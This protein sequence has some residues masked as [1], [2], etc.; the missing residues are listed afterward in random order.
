MGDSERGKTLQEEED[1]TAEFA[2]QCAQSWPDLLCRGKS[3]N[4]AETLAEFGEICEADAHT[5]KVDVLRT[6][7]AHPAFS[8]PEM[9]GRLQELLTDFCLAEGV[10][11]MQGLHEVAAVFAYIEAAG[12]GF[13]SSKPQCPTTLD[14]FKIFTRSFMPCFYDGEGFV[15]LHITLLFF[16]QLLLYHLPHLHNQLEEAGVAPVVYATP[17][18]I[19]LFAYK[20][21]LQVLLRLWHRYIR[22]GD[23]TFVP[24]LAVA[25][26]ELEKQAF[27]DAEEDDLNYAVDRTTITSLEKLQDVWN[28]A[29]I[30]HAKTPKSFSFRMSRVIMQVR[31]QLRKKGSGHPWADSVLARAEQE[32]RLVVLAREVVAQFVR[33]SDPAST[34][35]DSVQAVPSGQLPS[36]RLLLL[37]VRPRNAYDAEHLPNALHFHP[38]SLQRLAQVSAGMSRP[39]A[40]RLAA[41]LS[42]AISE[43]GG[44]VGA[45]KEA[46]EVKAGESTPEGGE[47][48]ALGAE[49]F[50][51]L[52]AAASEAWG[53]GWIS[54]SESAHL[55]VLGG[56]ADWDAAQI[57]KTDGGGVVAAL[58]EALTGQI[59]LPRVSV[60]LGGAAALQREA[61]KRGLKLESSASSA[62]KTDS[63][64][65]GN[66]RGLLSGA[67]ASLR[68]RAQQAQ[69]GL[70]Q[71]IQKSSD[72]A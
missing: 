54:E 58:F 20:T 31:E 69:Q 72:A 8:T 9:R 38:P 55:A 26:M 5:I 57:C 4:E 17:W 11:Y 12:D 29:E 14:C 50:Q 56:E 10:R 64:Y 6:R 37:D 42:R 30:L 40:E 22:R 7:G 25:V 41:A 70:A 34:S 65:P 13:R 27:L 24:F 45:R 35:L 3:Q 39:R 59:S 48:A 71:Q 33:A 19:T 2:R 68:Q 44:L 51:A 23:P 67:F 1:S 46:P 15:I 60:V 66:V 62:Q 21:P 52:Q 36:L 47:H 28:A 49:V 32:R 16:R 43:V 53:E 61:E 18:F 63:A